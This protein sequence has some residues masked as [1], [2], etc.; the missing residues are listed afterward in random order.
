MFIGENCG[1]LWFIKSQNDYIGW[2]DCDFGLY[3]RREYLLLIEGYFR[4]EKLENL[5]ENNGTH[6]ELLI[7]LRS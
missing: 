6:F 3:G 4:E 2:F 5:V 1:R 7:W